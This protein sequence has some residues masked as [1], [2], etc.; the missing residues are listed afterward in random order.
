MQRYR[1]CDI[2]GDKR[3]LH[4]SAQHRCISKQLP[5]ARFNTYCCHVISAPNGNCAITRDHPEVC[6]LL[7]NQIVCSSDILKNSR[8][9][10]RLDRRIPRCILVL[11]ADMVANIDIREQSVKTVIAVHQSLLHLELLRTMFSQVLHGRKRD[12][13]TYPA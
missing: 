9:T 2:I 7:R 4:N 11:Y 1:R 13:R 6:R 5:Y 3:C 10:F 12:N 8:R